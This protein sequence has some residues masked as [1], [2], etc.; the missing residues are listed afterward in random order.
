MTRRGTIDAVCQGAALTQDGRHT[1]LELMLVAMAAD[2]QVADRHAE[3]VPRLAAHEDGFVGDRPVARCPHQ[4]LA[5]RLGRSD[6]VVEESHGLEIKCPCQVE[7]EE[8][9]AQ[10]PV[11]EIE[12][13]NLVRNPEPSIAILDLRQRQAGSLQ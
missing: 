5:Q 2:A 11:R 9:V 1:E 13:V 4:S 3:L 12:K 10:G 6:D 8:R 7:T